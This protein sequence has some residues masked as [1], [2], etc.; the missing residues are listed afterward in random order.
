VGEILAF[1]SGKG[2]TGKTSVCAGIASCLAATG[3]RV[4]CIDGDVGLRNLDLSLGIPELASIPFTELLRGSCDFEDIP[5]HPL[6]SGLFLLTAPVT[7]SPE[8]I[9]PAAFSALM[10]RAREHYD[11]CL[12]DSPAGIGT[13]FGLCT[14]CADRVIVVSGSD[15]ASL[16]DA[17]SV[18]SLLSRRPVGSVKLIL[19]RAV[20]RTI[21]HMHLTVDDIMDSIGIPLLGIV[22]EDVSVPLSAA[23]GTP[24]VYYTGKRA[25]M[26]CLNISK[27]IAGRSV[28][29][30]RL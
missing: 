29:L 16:R 3:S 24:L 5:E 18:S 14:T 22:P 17:A 4:L 10:N 30:M 9:S 15:P 7:E 21:S 23:A 25:A 8:S 2:G 20:P 13:M 19:N 27:R 1:V 6:L 12:I 28:R 26:A 11:Y